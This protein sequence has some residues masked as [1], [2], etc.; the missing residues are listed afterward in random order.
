MR[1]SRHFSSILMVLAATLMLS[2]TAF[3]AEPNLGPGAA[4]PRDGAVSDVKAGSVLFFNLFSS[5]ASN[6]VGV[7]TRIEVTNTNPSASVAV[8]LFFVDGETCSPADFY[9]CLTPN[10]TYVFRASDFDPDTTGYVVAIAVNN[11]GCPIQ[12]NYLIGAEYVKLA[13]G[14]STSLNAESLAALRNLGDICNSA[15]SFASVLNF[16]GVDYDF[17]PATLAIDNIPSRMDNND[18]LIILNRP[19]GD[20][21]LGASRIGTIFGLL[22]NDVEVAHSFSINSSLCQFRFSFGNP[23]PRTVPRF[24]S[25]VPTGRTGW[26]KFYSN[27]GAPIF[28]AMINYNPNTATSTSAFN[29]GHNLHKLTFTTSSFTVPVFPAACAFR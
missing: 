18:T 19:G 21:G 10:Q 22:Y 24:T 12:F 11:S 16:N 25:V 17:V 23:T 14:H 28:G 4:F 1:T 8:H 15:N 20:L 29:G 6:P 5:S 26:V 2:V 27:T 13:S 3:A 7:N 9:F